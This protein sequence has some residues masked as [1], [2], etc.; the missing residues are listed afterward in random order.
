MLFKGFD[1][2]IWYNQL[3]L[4]AASLTPMPTVTFRLKV[5]PDLCN[6][7]GT[8][9]GGAI[10]TALDD[11]SFTTLA[12]TDRCAFWFKGAVSRSLNIVFI[13]PARVGEEVEIVVELMAA[14]RSLGMLN[15]FCLQNARYE[16]EE[17]FC[18]L[19]LSGYSE[20]AVRDEEGAGRNCNRYGGVGYH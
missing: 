14:G 11:C 17:R 19:I 7:T 4:T 6:L 15:V 3:K 10:A 12:L 20:C 16:A 5:K 2:D 9:H 8:M 1:S 18:K 13:K